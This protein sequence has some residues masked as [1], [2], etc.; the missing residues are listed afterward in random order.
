MNSLTIQS[1]TIRGG[2][3]FTTDREVQMN[4]VS[5]GFFA[6]LGT[7]IVAGRD[8]NEHDSLDVAPPNQPL[9]VSNSG[10][11][12]VIVNQ[13][14]VKRFFAGRSPLGARIAIGSAPDAK[15]DSEIV[16][17]VEN[18]SYRNV[19]EQ[20]EQAYF[21]VGTEMSGSNFYVRF[22]GTPESAFRSI[23]AV[24]RNADPTLPIRYFRTLDEQIDRSLNTE[25]MLAALSSSFGTLA[26]LLS[27]VGLYG[28]MSFVVIQRTREIGIRSALGA[29]PLSTIWLVLRDA[30]VM[31]AGGTAIALPCVWALGRLV[32]SQ[33]Y[34]VR[35]TDPV[36]ILAATLILCSTALGAAL[37]PARR[38]SAVNPTEALRFE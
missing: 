12:A 19:R 2:E 28:V 7:R 15:P 34:D 21:P 27:L 17:V 13:A 26:L 20:W 36:T 18:I 32:E 31:I 35:P 30:L 5:P 14:F 38:A 9:P 4:A 1:P 16:G 23:R 37:I 24:L 25:R 10:Q 3:R 8:F 6:T 29:T 33:L 22:R 11:R